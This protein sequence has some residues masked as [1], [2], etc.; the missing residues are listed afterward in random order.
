VSV[1]NFVYGHHS[2]YKIMLLALAGVKTVTCSG[3][4]IPWKKRAT[5]LSYVNSVVGLAYSDFFDRVL[6]YEG[7]SLLKSTRHVL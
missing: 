5:V 6:L 1:G 7:N 2:V 4:W 3:A